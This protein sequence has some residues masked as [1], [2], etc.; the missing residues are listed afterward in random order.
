VSI[1]VECPNPKCKK[2]LEAPDE[3]A[4]KR[5]R[6]PGCGWGMGVGGGIPRCTYRSYYEPDKPPFHYGTIGFRCAA[7]VPWTPGGAERSAAPEGKPIRLEGE[8]LK[9]LGKVAGRVR[10]CDLSRY[11]KG[12]SGSSHL[13]WTRAKPGDTLEL[14][15]PVERSGRYRLEAQFTKACDYA[16]VQLYLDGK[17]LCKPIDLYSINLRPSGCLDM[18]IH[19]LTAGEHNLRV[20]IVGSNEK[21]EK[22]YLFG[23]DYVQWVKRAGKAKR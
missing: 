9:I 14:C 13:Y 16:V 10:A 23:L 15:V 1:R 8:D 5:A 19:E 20:E 11:G 6:C 17:E 12:W 4:G 7:D 22:K 2:V 3:H 21:A 18:G